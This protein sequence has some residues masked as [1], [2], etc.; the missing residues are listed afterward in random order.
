LANLKGLVCVGG[1]V[2]FVEIEL[3]TLLRA[4]STNFGISVIA[5]RIHG[6]PGRAIVDLSRS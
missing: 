2:K 4:A 6:C 1:C 5:S 3:R